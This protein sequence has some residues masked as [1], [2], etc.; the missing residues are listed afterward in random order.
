M[1]FST[2]L[3]RWLEAHPLAPIPRL[4]F[5]LFRAMIFTGPTWIIRLFRVLL[6]GVLLVPVWIRMGWFYVTSANIRRNVRYGS[7]PRNFLDIFFPDQ[8]L[9]GARCPVVV[10]ISGGAWI[11]GYKAWGVIASRILMQ[12]GVICVLVDYRNFPQVSNT[13]TAICAHILSAHMLSLSLS[14]SLSGLCVH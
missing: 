3:K 14:L 11:V 1:T 7:Q 4:A 9:G 10:L 6:F 13:C 8:V 5:R 2:E 12:Y